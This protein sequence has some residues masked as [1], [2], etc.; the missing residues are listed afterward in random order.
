[1]TGFSARERAQRNN[2][3]QDARCL[4][5]PYE[6]WPGVP[7][8]LGATHDA[9]GVNFAVYSENADAI[10]LRLFDGATEHR[11]QLV[12]VT[13]HVW[14]GHVPR[15]APGAHYGFRAHG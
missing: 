12:D 13:G 10:E 1:S 11:H 8:P 4:S 15:L 14:H 6:V 7:Y 9:R 3:V 5:S 2:L